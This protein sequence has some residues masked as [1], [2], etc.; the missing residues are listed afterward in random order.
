ML[1]RFSDLLCELFRTA[2]TVPLESYALEVLRLLCHEMSCDM[3]VLGVGLAVRNGCLTTTHLAQLDYPSA[4]LPALY[5][6]ASNDEAGGAAGPPEGGRAPASP[7]LLRVGIDELVFL[8]T[9]L[10]G[11]APQTW[12]ALLRKPGRH[13]APV[14]LGFVGA[15]WPHLLRALSL[16]RQKALEACVAQTSAVGH[17]LLGVDY[18]IATCDQAFRNMIL[19][20][21]PGYRTL[22]FPQRVLRSLSAT[23]R[24]DGSV[25]LLEL[26]RM[27]QRLLCL[28]IAPA[29]VG[30]LTPAERKVAMQYAR[31]SSSREI[32]QQL[33]VSVNTVR[34]HL[35]HVFDKLDVHRKTD[36]I[37]RLS[38]A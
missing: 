37:R 18:G 4:R 19:R 14:D 5:A 13:A 29:Q 34:T 25:V 10:V 7:R 11:Q 2:E 36:L 32:A 23:G 22:V 9:P 35:A 21:W 15:L 3:G 12:L 33:R 31:G 1:D 38:V 20:E 28:A 26:S 16:N 6:S 8:S 24:Y 17:A 30:L 27:D